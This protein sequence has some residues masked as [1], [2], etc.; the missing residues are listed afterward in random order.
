M[1]LTRLIAQSYSLLFSQAVS[2]NGGAVPSASELAVVRALSS[3]VN[4]SSMR[5]AVRPRR[6]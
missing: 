4:D 2:C 5:G 6:R 1:P 3:L